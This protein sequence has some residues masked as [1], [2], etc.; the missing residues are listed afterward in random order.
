MRVFSLLPLLLLGCDTAPP[1]SEPTPIP[2]SYPEWKTEAVPPIESA[3]S[4]TVSLPV[5]H[6][7]AGHIDLR[8]YVFSFSEPKHITRIWSFIGVDQG[9]I[10][11]FAIDLSSHGRIYLRSLHKETIGIYDAW[12]FVDVNL[13]LENFTLITTAHATGNSGN[14]QFELVFEV[15]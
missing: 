1:T 6:M 10:G 7:D 3:R 14:I 12:D 8:D 5:Q 11:E 15:E 9:D 13:T 2:V 4:I